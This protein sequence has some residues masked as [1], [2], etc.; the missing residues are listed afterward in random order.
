MILPAVPL[1]IR[2]DSSREGSFLRK[3]PKRADQNE[4]CLDKLDEGYD[5]GWLANVAETEGRGRLEKR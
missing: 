4:A 2:P 1:F 3:L 5:L